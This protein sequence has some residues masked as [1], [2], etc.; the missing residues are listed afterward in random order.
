MS[1][2]KRGLEAVE[3]DGRSACEFVEGVGSGVYLVIFAACRELAEPCEKA[4][5]PRGFYKIDVSCV[6]LCGEGIGPR[7]FVSSWPN[8]LH[9]VACQHPSQRLDLVNACLPRVLRD[10]DPRLPTV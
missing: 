4:R 3:G 5:I 6:H 1:C 10:T 9:D 7:L 2:D 8:S